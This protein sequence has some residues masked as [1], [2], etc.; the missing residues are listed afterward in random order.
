MTITPNDRLVDWLGND[1]ATEF[2]LTFPAKSDEEIIV[3]VNGVVVTPPVFS[4]PPTADRIVFVIPPAT[5]DKIR[6]VG[7]TPVEQ[8]LVYSRGNNATSLPA[9]I[10][11]LD[12]IV[13]ALQEVKRKGDSIAGRALVVKEGQV[14]PELDLP[15][16]Y[17]KQIGIDGAGAAVPITPI[18]L[19][20]SVLSTNISDSTTAGR[21][22]LTAATVAAQLAALGFSASD[23]GLPAYLNKRKTLKGNGVVAGG[24]VDQAAAITAAAASLGPGEYLTGQH[25]TYKLATTAALGK[26]KLVLEDVTFECTDVT[27]GIP[28]ISAAGGVGGAVTCTTALSKSV[29]TFAVALATHG[30]VKGDL[31]LFEKTGALGT[32]FTDTCYAETWV[33]RI[34]EVA[35]DGLSITTEEGYPYSYTITTGNLTVRKINPVQDM[36]FENVSAFTEAGTPASMFGFFQYLYNTRWEGGTTTGFT[37]RARGWRRCFT[38]SVKH[39]TIVGANSG[40]TGATGYGDGLYDGGADFLLDTNTY[41]DTRHPIFGG[42]GGGIDY[43]ILA[44]NLTLNGGSA[45]GLDIHPEVVDATFTDCVINLANRFRATT[46]NF[47]GVSMQGALCTARN[48]TVRGASGPFSGSSI[49]ATAILMQPLTRYPDDLHSVIDCQVRD[50]TNGGMRGVAGQN[51]KPVGDVAFSF[52]NTHIRAQDFNPSAARAP[53][54]FLIEAN[55]AAGGIV[56]EASLM[57]C[58]A[59]AAGSAVRFVAGTGKSIISPSIIG[60]VFETSRTDLPVIE[61]AGAGT[62]DGA[63]ISPSRVF[64]G[65]YGV[66]QSAGSRVSLRPGRIGGYAV[67]PFS[68]LFL[69]VVRSFD[70]GIPVPASATIYEVAVSLPEDIYLLSII[71]K[72]DSGTCS[73]LP[74]TRLVDIGSAI[75]V[76]TTEAV[77]NINSLIAAGNSLRFGVLASP[78][79]VSPVRLQVSFRYREHARY[80]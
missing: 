79:P 52:V 39:A 4:M 15:T 27:D 38:T 13:K 19:P 20:T 70:F 51:L 64:G 56:R 48:I 8:R 23:V 43:R 55:A 16:F 21:A 60:G 63:D 31:V 32:L 59:K 30:I 12:D 62:I 75:A 78:A 29:S 67:A 71:T 44:R 72:L 34:R 18:E 11:Q 1:T 49:D 28:A 40:D 46:G 80:S 3:T 50:I 41:W 47:E 76:T 36:R 35:S 5:G 65:N 10:E 22:L 2:T 33:A 25:D 42:N 7:N 73:I 37:D 58:S 9:V 53:Q 57:G 74:Q 14:G 68:G 61:L 26:A 45:L 69:D 6:I 24:S 77:T 54:G 66:L 17:G